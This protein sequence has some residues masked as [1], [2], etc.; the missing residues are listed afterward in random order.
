MAMRL[1]E[2]RLARRY[3]PVLD[4]VDLVLDQA[5]R[6]AEQ[7]ARGSL[8]RVEVAVTITDGIPDL[9]CEAHEQLLGAS[10]WDAWRSEG[11]A[12]TTTIN[13]A[14]SLVIINAQSCRGRTEE[15]D[16]TVIHEL[17]HAAQFNRPGA[18]ENVRRGI[19]F[20]YGMGWLEDREVRALNRRVDRDER[21][22]E[23]AER[24]HRQLAK[25]VA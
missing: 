5:V 8:G 19:A 17:V 13:P 4:R 6:L 3:R 23:A 11:C 2:Y 22:A 16:K 10:N 12:G 24:L 9:V 15:I 21:E 14:G 25:A 18:R 20:N 7:H 1:V